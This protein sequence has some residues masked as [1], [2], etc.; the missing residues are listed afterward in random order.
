MKISFLKYYKK[1]IQDCFGYCLRM[2]AKHFS[3]NNLLAFIFCLLLLLF[4][5]AI[6]GMYCY[7][8]GKIKKDK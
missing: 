5:V 4:P 6:Y 1:Q 7:D 3:I 2:T 8:S